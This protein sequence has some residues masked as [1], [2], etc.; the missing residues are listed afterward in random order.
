MFGTADEPLL[1]HASASTL[2]LLAPQS[3]SEWI[4]K[5]K[6]KRVRVGGGGSEFMMGETETVINLQNR[7]RKKVRARLICSM[8]DVRNN[9]ANLKGHFKQLGR[10]HAVSHGLT[11]I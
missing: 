4:S 11:E 8:K 3:L 9:A 2:A 5:C 1:R 6:C 7:N 10:G